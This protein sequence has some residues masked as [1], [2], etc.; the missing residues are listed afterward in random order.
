MHRLHKDKTKHS[1][2]IIEILKNEIKNNHK[3]KKNK[4]CNS[5]TIEH[6]P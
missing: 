1:Y 4:S 2:I 5:L 6:S 3:K